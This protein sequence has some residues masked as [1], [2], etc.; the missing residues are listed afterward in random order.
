MNVECGFRFECN[1]WFLVRLLQVHLYGNGIYRSNE[2]VNVE[3]NLEIN[4]KKKN[5][6]YYILLHQLL[7]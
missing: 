2:L 7:I 4:M 6:C 1:K 3:Q 5:I